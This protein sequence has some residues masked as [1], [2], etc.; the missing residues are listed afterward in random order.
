MDEQKPC[1]ACGCDH[2]SCYAAFGEFQIICP[3]C[4][5]VGSIADSEDEAWALWNAEFEATQ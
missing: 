2:A 1:P 5:T 4:E 3:V